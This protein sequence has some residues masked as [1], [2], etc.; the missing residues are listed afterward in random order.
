VFSFAL[1]VFRQDPH[2]VFI[3]AADMV[4]FLALIAF[5]IAVITKLGAY[6]AVSVELSRASQAV[7]VILGVFQFGNAIGNKDWLYLFFK[8]PVFSLSERWAKTVAVVAGAAELLAY[9][10]K[11]VLKAS[12]G[13]TV[14]LPA[15]LAL[16]DNRQSLL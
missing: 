8:S 13:A 2:L 16:E 12:F 9:E 3:L 11:S 4:Y 14:C 1:E 15:D 6:I 7:L 5:F 10:A